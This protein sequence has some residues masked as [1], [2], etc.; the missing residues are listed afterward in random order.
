MLVIRTVHGT[1]IRPHW[2]R[3][4][5]ITEVDA[6]SGKERPTPPHPYLHQGVHRCAACWQER[7]HPLA[8]RHR[9]VHGRPVR[10]AGVD[11]SEPD[12]EAGHA[13]LEL[14]ILKRMSTLM[15]S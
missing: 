2:I 11:V 15:T 5:S 1:E 10:S 14:R 6:G 9:A 4:D 13:P 3:S 12:R 7:I 8:H